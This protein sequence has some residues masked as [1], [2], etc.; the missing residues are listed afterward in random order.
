MQMLMKKKRNMEIA[1]IIDSVLYEYYSEKGMNVPKW[2]RIEPQWWI[3]YLDS[4]GID[5]R[6]P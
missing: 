6:N 2:K 1:Q 5:S 3:D 4:L